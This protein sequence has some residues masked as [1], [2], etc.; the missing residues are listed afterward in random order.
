MHLQLWLAAAALVAASAYQA[1]PTARV[2]SPARATMSMKVKPRR[3]EM[4]GKMKVVLQDK[5]EGLG[6]AGDIKVVRNGYYLNA[7]L[8]R[9]LAARVTDELLADVEA[10]AAERATAEAAAKKAAAAVAAKLEG[11]SA[12]VQITKRVG[13]AGAIFGSVS[14]QQVLDAFAAASGVDFAASTKVEL[15]T[16]KA[17]GDYDVGIV[18]HPLV[19]ARVEIAVVPE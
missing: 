8:P 14:P 3:S 2:R 19:T 10:K 4:T 12:P 7:L 6:L 1:L 11:L 13:E 17:T 5:V 16:I 15:P 9:K 18:L